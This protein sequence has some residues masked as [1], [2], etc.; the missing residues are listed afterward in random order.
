MFGGQNP[1]FRA[2]EARENFREFSGKSRENHRK[3][4]ACGAQLRALMCRSCIFVLHVREHAH[5]CSKREVKLLCPL[6]NDRHSSDSV[7]AG[8]SRSFL[9][10]CLSRVCD[11]AIVLHVCA[12]V[13]CVGARARMCVCHQPNSNPVAR[14]HCSGSCTS[15]MTMLI[16]IV[17]PK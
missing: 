16:T 13:C 8:S 12:C 5:G 2:P 17:T 3:S 7:H 1:L 10:V 6:L 4:H 9:Q 14:F 15:K 11:C